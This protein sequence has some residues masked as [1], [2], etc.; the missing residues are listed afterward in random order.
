M[1]LLRG[2]IKAAKVMVLA[3]PIVVE[4][5]KNLSVEASGGQG[6]LAAPPQSPDLVLVEVETS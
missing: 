5:K 2:S 4:Q 3:L 6:W 1:V